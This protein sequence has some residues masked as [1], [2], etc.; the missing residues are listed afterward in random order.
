[1]SST[2]IT[3]GY[4][5]IATVGSRNTPTEIPRYELEKSQPVL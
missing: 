1:M 2:F 3:A 4:F 5:F